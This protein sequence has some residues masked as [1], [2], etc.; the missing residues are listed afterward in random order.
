MI[1]GV[2]KFGFKVYY[3]LSMRR[4]QLKP[5]NARDVG[6]VTDNIILVEALFNKMSETKTWRQGASKHFMILQ[7]GLKTKSK[8]IIIKIYTIIYKSK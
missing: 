8:T 4:P 5:S 7:S 6:E 1:K 2:L 3:S